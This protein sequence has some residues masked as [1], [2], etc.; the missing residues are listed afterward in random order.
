M[1]DLHLKKIPGGAKPAA[2]PKQEPFPT[3]P[4]SKRLADAREREAALEA[5]IAQKKTDLQKHMS[6]IGDLAVKLSETKKYI[7]SVALLANAQT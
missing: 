3:V 1:I 4:V 6:A 5:E 7:T 2:A